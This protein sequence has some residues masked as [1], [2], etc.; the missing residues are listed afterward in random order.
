M[1]SYSFIYDTKRTL[2]RNKLKIILIIRHNGAIVD[3]N[4]LATIL[5]NHL[6]K[7]IVKLI[8]IKL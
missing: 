5:N 7:L 2:W 3:K 6:L 1:L 8:T 4:R